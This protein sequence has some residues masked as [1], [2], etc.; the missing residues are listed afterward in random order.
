MNR[1][2]AIAILAT[3]AAA[4]GNAFA[5]D[6]TVDTSPFLSNRSRAEVQAEQAAFRQSGVNPWSIAYN[7][8]RGFQGTAT[9]AQ[10]VAD[11]IAARER[12]AAM[13]RE[14]SGSAWLA[15]R[16]AE[17]PATVAGQARNAQ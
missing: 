14:D 16:P 13:T 11:Y 4:A 7:P 5:D 9:R 2:L 3:A 12:V 15:R 8:L 17:V 6:I 1:K 10:V